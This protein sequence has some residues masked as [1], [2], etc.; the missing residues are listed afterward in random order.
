M[1]KR[2]LG[3]ATFQRSL[4]RRVSSAQ[5]GKLR[6]NKWKLTAALVVSNKPFLLVFSLCVSPPTLTLGLDR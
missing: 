4:E 2:P 1:R 6:K 3:R 5:R